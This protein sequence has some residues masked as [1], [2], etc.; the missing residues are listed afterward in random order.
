MTEKKK[1]NFGIL[2]INKGSLGVQKKIGGKSTQK[3]A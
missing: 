3:N 1:Q 2:E